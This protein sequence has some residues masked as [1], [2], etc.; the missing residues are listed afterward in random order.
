MYNEFLISDDK[1]LIDVDIVCK[2][3]SRS[4]W[5]N[6]RSAETIIK[7]IHHS[8]CF[9]IYE[10]RRQV[11]FARIVTDGATIYYLCDVFIDEEF[12]G[13]GLGKKLVEL[14]TKEYEGISGILRTLDAH[15]LYEQYGFKKDAERFMNSVPK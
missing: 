3:L 8:I 9:G 15:S 5:A 12:R 11:G 4:H 7:S 10:S 6:K 1:S 14:I 2:F 13:K